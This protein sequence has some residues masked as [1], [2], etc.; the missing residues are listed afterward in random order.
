MKDHFEQW[1]SGFSL[2]VGLA[3]NNMVE[4]AVARQGL[5]MAWTM[6]F[7]YIQLELDYKVVL[8]WLTNHNASYPTN[9]IPLICDCR[10]LLD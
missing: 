5:A 3:T 2:H 6:G 4:L 7:K 10:S 1:I 9:M 8:T